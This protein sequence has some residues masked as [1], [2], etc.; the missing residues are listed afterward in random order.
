[1]DAVH[2]YL[3]SQEPLDL[4]LGTLAGRSFTYHDSQ[5]SWQ[6]DTPPAMRSAAPVGR[7][8]AAE[9][10]WLGSNSPR[11]HLLHL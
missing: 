9:H 5:A 4:P 1:M 2:I 7:H 10:L 6:A 8:L 3:D 11:A